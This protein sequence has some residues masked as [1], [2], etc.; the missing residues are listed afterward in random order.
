MQVQTVASQWRKVSAIG[1]G[2]GVQHAD[3]SLSLVHRITAV[4]VAE[5]Q[6][7]VA[8]YDS[9]RTSEVRGYTSDGGL[10]EQ[11]A[12]SDAAL[13]GFGGGED[14]RRKVGGAEE[15]VLVADGRV[16]DEVS[17]VEGA[18]TVGLVD[19]CDL[20]VECSQERC[21]SALVGGEASQDSGIEGGGVGVSDALCDG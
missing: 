17:V 1:A 8:I 20:Q 18:E 4:S 21:D 10:S 5:R 7:S 13:G 15:T 12:E 3:S 16:G 6:I 19:G 11:F 14:E 9:N 2:S